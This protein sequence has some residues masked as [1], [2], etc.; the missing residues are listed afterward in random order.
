MAINAYVTRDPPIVAALADDGSVAA[1]LNPIQFVPTSSEWDTITDK[2]FET[3]DDETLSTEGGVLKFKSGSYKQLTDR[4]SIEGVTLEDNKTFAQ[5]GM[6]ECS[7]LDIEK[8][9]S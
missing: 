6:E 5:L 1:K 3:V 9:F 2:P 7:I 8:M 4:P